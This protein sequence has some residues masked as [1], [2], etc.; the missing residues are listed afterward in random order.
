[1][2]FAPRRNIIALQ[3][4]AVADDGTRIK[5]SGDFEPMPADNFLS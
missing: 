3:R 5:I 1:M 4:G 2:E